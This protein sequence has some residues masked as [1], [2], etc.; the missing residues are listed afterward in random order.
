MAPNS[1]IHTI[2][3]GI[4][5]KTNRRPVEIILSNLAI[6]GVDIPIIPR[7]KPR[8]CCDW[9]L[10]YIGKLVYHPRGQNASL[11][12]IPHFFGTNGVITV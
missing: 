5:L 7:N 8:V 4:S 12:S 6:E 11:P 1:L 2:P 9:V 10:S 3:V